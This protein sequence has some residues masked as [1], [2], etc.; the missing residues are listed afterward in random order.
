[1]KKLLVTSACLL[2]SCV[3]G[4]A[5]AAKPEKSQILH[6]GCI[7]DDMG[8]AMVYTEISVSSNATGHLN[9]VAGS[10]DSCLVGV[11]ADGVEMYEDF[12]RTGSDCQLGGAQL[13]DLAECADV[14]AGDV[15]GEVVI[16]D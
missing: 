16:Q 5:M 3:A 8:A 11:D 14:V 10:I 1:M 13:G 6:C 7:F 12:V 9:H 4:A 2:L 15:C